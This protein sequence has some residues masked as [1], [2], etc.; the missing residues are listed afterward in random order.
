MDT[1]GPEA[2]RGLCLGSH[3]GSGRPAQRLL[4]ICGW[5]PQCRGRWGE[6]SRPSQRCAALL[7]IWG[8][9]RGLASAV[10][11]SPAPLLPQQS[12][13]VL[14]PA[15]GRADTLREELRRRM[16][17]KRLAVETAIF[18]QVLPCGARGECSWPAGGRVPQR[19][20]GPAES[21]ALPWI[22]HRPEP[23]GP[24]HRWGWRG[25]GRNR[26]GSQEQG[27]GCPRHLP[28]A[29]FR[30]KFNSFVGS[31]LAPPPPPQVGSLGRG[32]VRPACSHLPKTWPGP[33]PWQRL[34]ICSTN[35]RIGGWTVGR[36]L[37]R[38]RLGSGGADAGRLVAGRAVGGWR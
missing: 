10:A 26:D 35:G 13:H 18:P 21:Q 3:V 34:E 17:A 5:V 38:R 15:S 30:N 2:C 1:G 37:E 24:A 4:G 32:P 28:R 9:R 16:L 19:A 12:R 29:R 6:A 25:R 27:N 20:L 22:R 7:C 8:S 23:V 33:G 11:P 36:I 14:E 31:L